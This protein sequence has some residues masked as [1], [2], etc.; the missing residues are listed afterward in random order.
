MKI[1][2]KI[3]AIFVLSKE[4]SN[5]EYDIKTY[6][7]VDLVEEE[8]HGHTFVFVD[9]PSMY[10]EEVSDYQE[11][12]MWFRNYADALD[13]LDKKLI[14]KKNVFKECISKI[15]SVIEQGPRVLK[16][17][18]VANGYNRWQEVD[19]VQDDGDDF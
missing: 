9:L 3:P 6:T 14:A 1:L 7:D 13:G 16:I 10:G 8:S 11:G 12:T 5:F 19:Y 17:A 18:P 15:N 4:G 2:E